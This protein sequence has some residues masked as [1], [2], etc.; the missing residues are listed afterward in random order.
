M[1]RIGRAPIEV[2]SGVTVA[3]DDRTIT[4]TGPNGQLSHELAG[5][6]TVR[7]DD[8]SVVVERAN[9]ER[10]NRALHGLTRSLLSNM[11]TGVSQGFRK[12][13]RCV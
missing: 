8:G 4:V 7:T 3:V 6:M 1:S 10:Q 5:D 9:D 11:V 2:P 13:L 12:E